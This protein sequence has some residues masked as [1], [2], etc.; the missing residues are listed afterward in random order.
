MRFVVFEGQ[1]REVSARQAVVLPPHTKYTTLLKKRQHEIWMIFDPNP[2][3]LEVLHSTKGE[4]APFVT[5][6]V[7]PEIWAG[8]RGGLRDLLRW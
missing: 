7:N 1:S 2:H 4:P 8:V 6:F 3:L 5:T